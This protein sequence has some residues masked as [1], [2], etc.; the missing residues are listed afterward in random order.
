MTR[1]RTLVLTSVLG[2]LTAVLFV[3]FVLRL[4]QV[5]TTGP[6]FGPRLFEVGQARRLAPQIAEGG[7]FLFKDPLTSGV[8]RELYLQHTGDDV[9]QGWIA[10]EARAPGAAATCI[11]ETGRKQGS[12]RDPCSKKTYP[13]S[14]E[15]LTTYPAT[16]NDEGIVE[17]DLRP[18]P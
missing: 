2:V 8:G 13:P 11:L 16:V 1:T 6:E 14:G 3:V 5:D 18:R 12:L 9:Q 7:P 10:F 15:G 17:V 4:D